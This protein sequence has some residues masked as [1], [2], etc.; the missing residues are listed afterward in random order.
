MLRFA[1]VIA[2]QDLL[3]YQFHRTDKVCN[4]KELVVSRL[5]LLSELNGTTN[6]LKD[7]MKKIRYWRLSAVIIDFDSPQFRQ[8]I[9]MD[10]NN[11]ITLGAAGIK[12][13]GV[14]LSM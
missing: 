10:P 6:I 1:H 9:M 13:N 2:A 11:M 3:F 7:I 8:L 4:L 14:R 5:N 12:I